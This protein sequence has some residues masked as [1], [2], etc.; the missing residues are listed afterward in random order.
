MLDTIR[1]QAEVLH[2]EFGDRDLIVK[3][4]FDAVSAFLDARYEPHRRRGKA[5]RVGNLDPQYT[6]TMTAWA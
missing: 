4:D 1:E 2:K 5:I 6:S 3:P